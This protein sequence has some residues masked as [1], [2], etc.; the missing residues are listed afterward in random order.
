MAKPSPT[1][2]TRVFTISFPPELAKQVDAV[3]KAESRTISELFREAFRTYR[4]E[5]N[6]RKLIA[7]RAEGAKRVSRQYSEDD[8]EAIVD[9]IRREQ[10]AR[11]KRLA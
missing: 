8:V 6:E 4:M 7:A 2:G 5:R 10:F 3:A 11:R 9:E 1:R